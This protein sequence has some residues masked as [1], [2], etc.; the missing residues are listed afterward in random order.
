[1]ATPM[2]IRA[3]RG[4]KMLVIANSAKVIAPRTSPAEQAMISEYSPKKPGCDISFSK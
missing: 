3:M 2:D 1:M 4:N